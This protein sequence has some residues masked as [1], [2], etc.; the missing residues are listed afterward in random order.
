MPLEVERKRAIGDH[1]DQVEE[2]LVA[3][4]WRQAAPV[5]EVD[6]YYSR[7]DVDYLR[8]VECLRVRR[9]NG[10][11]E[12]TYKPSST[13]ATRRSDG[14][15]AKRETNVALADEAGEAEALL[16]AV[17]MVFL[18]RVEKTRVVWHHP[19][20]SDTSVAVDK[21]GG[22]GA[23]VEVEVISAD[24]DQAAAELSRVEAELD[25]ARY[26]VMTLPYRDL[27][28]AASRST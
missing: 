19:E 21:V 22:V 1:A 12:I 6:T 13:D 2:R 14:V 16:E 8:T 24:A 28:R 3:R 17:G 26:P 23:F 4:G 11:A 18:T 5:A 27:V 9:R 25:L 10:F 20:R 7:P 15:V